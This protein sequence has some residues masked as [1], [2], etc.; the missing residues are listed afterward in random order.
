M[1][2]TVRYWTISALAT[3]ALGCGG[4]GEHAAAAGADSVA[5][6]PVQDSAPGA[7]GTTGM[8][9]AMPSTA[10]MEGMEAHLRA[11][12]GAGP[13]SVVAMLPEHWQAVANLI[14]QTNRE[15]REMGMATDAAWDATVDS[16]RQDLV[17]LP[18]LGPGELQ[19]ILPAHRARVMRLIE[20]HRRMLSNM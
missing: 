13:D 4:E 11:L 20:A 8:A 9:H 12:D 16:L 6:T 10:M 14:A 17:R 2:T 1:L 7:S 5:S 3:V 18:E 19:D 15:M